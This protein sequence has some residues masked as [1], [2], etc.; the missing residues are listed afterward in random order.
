VSNEG[1]VR[2]NRRQGEKKRDRVCEKSRET[3]RRIKVR[4]IRE[5]EKSTLRFSVRKKEKFKKGECE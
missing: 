3:R 5:R 4:L 1:Y 2:E